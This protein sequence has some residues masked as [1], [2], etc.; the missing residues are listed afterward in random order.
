MIP[1][2][3][4]YNH[5]KDFDE[6]LCKLASQ[7]R[8]LG[9]LNWPDTVK[10]QFLAGVAKG[11]RPRLAFQYPAITHPKQIEALQGFL[12][13][14]GRDHPALD[15]MRANAESFLSALHMIDARGTTRITEISSQLYGRPS[16]TLPLYDGVTILD[17]AR[18]FLTTADSFTSERG[19]QEPEY[20]DA[21]ELFG[22]LGRHLREAGLIGHIDLIFDA[23]IASKVSVTSSAIRIRSGAKFSIY[24]ADQLLHHEVMTHALTSINGRNQPILSSM[25]FTAPRITRAQEGLAQFAELVSGAIHIHRLKRVALRIIAID[26]ALSGADFMQ[27]YDFFCENGQNAEES[28]LSAMRILRGGTPNGGIVFLKDNVYLQGMLEVQAFFIQAFQQQD[29][30]TLE[31]LFSGKMALEDVPALLAMQQQGLLQ[32]PEFIPSWYQNIHTLVARLAFTQFASNL[33]TS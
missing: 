29:L 23:Q 16:D 6:R 12:R 33:K 19:Y 9:E 8:V 24:E 25:Q 18:F 28:Y 3:S 27:L 1:L 10:E 32:A 20:I 22:F 5:I 11:E 2:R 30:H 14:I 26:M 31:I 17:A 4:E 13:D 7:V 15:L 21:R